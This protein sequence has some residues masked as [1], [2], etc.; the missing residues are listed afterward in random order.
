MSRYRRAPRELG[1][2]LLGLPLAVAGLAYVVVGV[3]VGAVL[4]VTLLGLPVLAGA[5]RGARG[6]GA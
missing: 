2:A 1:Y 6:W 4:S 5:V 3:L